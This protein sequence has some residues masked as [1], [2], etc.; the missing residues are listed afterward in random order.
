MANGNL[1][2]S[3]SGVQ[4]G[5]PF[6]PLPFSLAIHYIASSTKCNFS[7]WYMDDATIAGD[8]R[9]VCDNIKRCSCMLADIGIFLNPSKSELVY[10]G[11]DETV[12]LRETQ[13]INS[14]LEDVSYV[15]KKDVILLGSPL[16][17]TAIRP[18]FQ[19]YDLCAYLRFFEENVL[20]ILILFR[21]IS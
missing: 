8:P 4:Q 10:L 1:I 12:F 2:W 19:I 9:F 3:H 14:T 15:E 5:D 13:C 18:Q 6:G 17:S 16:S 21:L 20:F 7:V 11:L